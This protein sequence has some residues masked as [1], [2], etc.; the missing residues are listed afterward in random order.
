MPNEMNVNE[1]LEGLDGLMKRTDPLEWQKRAGIGEA[2][3]FIKDNRAALQAGL[4]GPGTLLA[5]LCRAV[6]AALRESRSEGGD[7]MPWDEFRD[8]PLQESLRAELLGR[9]INP[10]DVVPFRMNGATRKLLESMR[11]RIRNRIAQFAG[12][13]ECHKAKRDAYLEISGMMEM[14]DG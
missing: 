4:P 3:R 7:P 2:M 9:E 12:P 6:Y 11:Q 1:L 10:D 5:G 14:I 8:G 13:G